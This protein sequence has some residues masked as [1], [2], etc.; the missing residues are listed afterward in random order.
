MFTLNDLKN[1]I[2]NIPQIYSDKIKVYDEIIET[3]PFNFI[4]LG[5]YPLSKEEQ[6]ALKEHYIC[7]TGDLDLSGE[8]FLLIYWQDEDF[9]DNHL[10]LNRLIQLKISE[11]KDLYIDKD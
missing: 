8:P 6:F 11:I 1:P 3:F 5:K 9:V 2:I 7:Q 4:G 10:N